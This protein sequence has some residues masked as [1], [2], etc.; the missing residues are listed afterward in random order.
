[1]I[2]PTGK[3]KL[4]IMN[5]WQLGYLTDYYYYCK[6]LRDK[7]LTNETL[8]NSMGRTAREFAITRFSAE[9]H[10]KKLESV[11]LEAVNRRQHP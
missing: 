10:V 2:E 3:R 11:L 7:L 5:R 1:M 8:R 4:L 9:T 6:Y